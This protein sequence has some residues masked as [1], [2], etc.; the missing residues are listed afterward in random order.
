MFVFYK[1]TLQNGRQK[2]THSPLPSAAASVYL[3]PS[4]SGDAGLAATLSS[5]PTP[6]TC[7][8]ERASARQ[9]GPRHDAV[10]NANRSQDPQRRRGR[11]PPRAQPGR[12]CRQR[13]PSPHAQP[14]RVSHQPRARPSPVGRR[15]GGRWMFPGAPQPLTGPP[16]ALLWGRF[17][18]NPHP[19]EATASPCSPCARSPRAGLLRSHQRVCAGKVP[20]GHTACEAAA[21]PS[22]GGKRRSAARGTHGVL[23]PPQPTPLCSAGRRA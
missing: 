18:P 6:G 1:N 12:R 16:G 2:S 23:L 3:R 4:Q 5:S 17:A 11:E 21:G 10:V 19:S 20:C 15:L 7:R 22:A 14:R 9:H 13:G 8:A